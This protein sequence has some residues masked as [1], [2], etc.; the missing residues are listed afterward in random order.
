MFKD[1]PSF[2]LLSSAVADEWDHY[3]DFVYNS[4][5]VIISGNFPNDVTTVRNSDINL[6]FLGCYFGISQSSVH[7]SGIGILYTDGSLASRRRFQSK[8]RYD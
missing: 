2:Q 6:G 3:S 5:M 1:A 8:Q 7:S 4:Y